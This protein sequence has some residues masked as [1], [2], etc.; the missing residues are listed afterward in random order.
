M[1]FQKGLCKITNWEL[2]NPMASKK[3]KESVN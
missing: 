1:A 3:I 2:K